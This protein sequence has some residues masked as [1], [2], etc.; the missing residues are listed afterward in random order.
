MYRGKARIADTET[1]AKLKVS[2]FGPFWGDY[3]IID[4]DPEYDWAVVGGPKRRYFW[5]LSR[6]PALNQEI[7]GGILARLSD[8]GYSTDRLLW[9]LRP[10]P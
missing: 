2:F 9:T 3:W 4:L 8:Q 5:I 6:R 10:D 1:Q 7:M